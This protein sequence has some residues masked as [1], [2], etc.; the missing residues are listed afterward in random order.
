[1]Q[2]NIFGG[3]FKTPNYIIIPIIFHLK[4]IIVKVLRI[5]IYFSYTSL[6][7]TNNDKKIHVI[8]IS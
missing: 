4:I 3:N 1:M 5:M 6:V 2:I 7:I 8:I